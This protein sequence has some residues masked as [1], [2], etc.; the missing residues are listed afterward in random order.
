[1]IHGPCGEQHKNALC[2]VEGTNGKWYCSKGFPKPLRDT[3][4]GQEDGYPLY[5]RRSG[6]CHITRRNQQIDN[7]W[8]VPYNAWLTTK[9]DAHINV[10]ICNS[11]KAVKYLY[12][13]VH[14][15]HDRAKVLSHFFFITLNNVISLPTIVDL[16]MLYIFF[17][18]FQGWSCQRVRSR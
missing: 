3:T 2:M 7:S 15:G 1:M 8:I 11:V 18:N 16:I 10:G 4:I 17:F 12:K 6:P 13:Y 5:R 9:Y 14:K